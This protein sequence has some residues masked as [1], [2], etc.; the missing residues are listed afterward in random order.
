VKVGIDEVKGSS[1][2]TVALS[3]EGKPLNLVPLKYDEHWVFALKSVLR[4]LAVDIR[5]ERHTVEVIA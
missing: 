5:H 1:G 3:V 4:A 2:Q